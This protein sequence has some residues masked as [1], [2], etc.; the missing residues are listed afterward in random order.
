[1]TDITQGPRASGRLYRMVGRAGRPAAEG[2][3]VRP[4]SDQLRFGDPLRTASRI[5]WVRKLAG[6]VAPLLLV[7]SL[8]SLPL[9]GAN[10]VLVPAI[11]W[12]WLVW[13]ICTTLA[14]T[15][16]SLHTA[17]VAQRN[18]ITVHLPL[19]PDLVEGRR[20]AR[21]ILAGTEDLPDDVGPR[22]AARS[23]LER[24]NRAAVAL[25]DNHYS[26]VPA[27]QFDAA[28]TDG[29]AAVDLL[30]QLCITLGSFPDGRRRDRALDDVEARTSRPVAAV[31]DRP[32]SPAGPSEDP[33][34]EFWVPPS[35]Y[36][37]EHD[38]P[39]QDN[40]GLHGR[41]LRFPPQGRS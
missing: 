35:T 20:L 36:S 14:M 37:H 40:D 15:A 5:T 11:A 32:V 29:R 19:Y 10:A 16:K 17:V 8:P 9:T 7:V 6:L 31:Q 26:G 38:G 28:L 41:I 33:M 22:L 4:V 12:G 2:R 13:Q 21:M 3:Q 34:A 24:V 30:R 23:L 18:L 25:A 1:M 39:R 27:P